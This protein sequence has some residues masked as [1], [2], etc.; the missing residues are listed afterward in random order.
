MP[1]TLPPFVSLAVGTTFPALLRITPL[2]CT[3]SSRC[4]ASS[5]TFVRANKCLTANHAPSSPI[6][7]NQVSQACSLSLSHEASFASLGLLSPPAPP[8]LR[9]SQ[10]PTSHPQGTVFMLVL[11]R[12]ARYTRVLRNSTSHAPVLALFCPR[13]LQLAALARGSRVF[14][15]CPRL[16][17]Q[18]SARTRAT[19]QVSVELHLLS[20]SYSSY[21]PRLKFSS[22]PFCH[23]H[24]KHVFRGFVSSPTAVAGHLSKRA[25]S[26]P[27]CPRY[28]LRT[29]T[30]SLALTFMLPTTSVHTS[31]RPRHD[32]PLSSS[33]GQVPL[34]SPCFRPPPAAPNVS[35][36]SRRRKMLFPPVAAFQIVRRS[37][38]IRTRTARA[39]FHSTS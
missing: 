38:S 32:A 37:S 2:P 20:P 13:R 23:L 3:L 7:Q 6:P 35:T 18:F 26:M 27:I 8:R 9:H 21:V 11:C 36:R 30:S 34:L 1:L 15:Y 31:T 19:P 33:A 22:L 29:D 4:R 25:P 17:R 14:G 12:N 28:A 10:L 5:T 24:R 39:S 16:L